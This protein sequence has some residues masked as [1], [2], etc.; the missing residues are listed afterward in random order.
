MSDSAVRGSDM[1]PSSLSLDAVFFECVR[2]KTKKEVRIKECGK[3]ALM[4]LYAGARSLDMD[5]G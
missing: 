4:S 2:L 5:A 1:V 3:K